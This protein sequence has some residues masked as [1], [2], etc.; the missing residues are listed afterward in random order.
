MLGALMQEW[1]TIK[2][3]ANTPLV[4][5]PGDYVD[6]TYLQ[7]LCFWI[8]VATASSASSVL[9]T[10][11]T[12]PLNENALFQNLI[13]SSKDLTTIAGTVTP[14]AALAQDCVVPPARW[15]RWSVTSAAAWSATF[16]IFV[17]ANDVRP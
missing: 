8:D 9:L 11:Q 12:A 5:L 2:G 3:A 10:F 16:R 7:D 1:I 17:A 15:V 6:V 14:V 4:Q 13:S